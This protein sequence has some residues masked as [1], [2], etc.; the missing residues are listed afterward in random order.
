VKSVGTSFL[1]TCTATPSFVKQV[2]I[3]FRNTVNTVATYLADTCGIYPDTLL[4]PDTLIYPDGLC[5]PAGTV[6]NLLCTVTTTGTVSVIINLIVNVLPGAN[7]WMPLVA[8]PR[9]GTVNR[10][11]F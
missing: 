6:Y 8:N 3:Y 4:T 11:P 9:R 2:G 10:R 1:K 5:P 7:S